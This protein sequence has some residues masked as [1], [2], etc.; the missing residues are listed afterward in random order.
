MAIV[1][2]SSISIQKET[3]DGNQ[4]NGAFV[5]SIVIIRTRKTGLKLKYVIRI[6]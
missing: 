5:I 4:N 6:V 2:V 1:S 3:I